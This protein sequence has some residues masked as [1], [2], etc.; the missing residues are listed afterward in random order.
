[1]LHLF[2]R[3]R[4]K[5][6]C[7]YHKHFVNITFS[8]KKFKQILCQQVR[9]STRRTQSLQPRPDP[10]TDPPDLRNPQEIRESQQPRRDV[11]EHLPADHRKRRTDNS[12]ERRH[13]ADDAARFN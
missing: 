3:N 12:G 8:S 9:G 6:E 1:M 13:S 4:K 2:N 11:R 10:H 7:Q 5:S